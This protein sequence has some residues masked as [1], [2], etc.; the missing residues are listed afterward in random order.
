[1]THSFDLLDQPW[2][3]CTDT[4]GRPCLLGIRQVLLRADR[5][6]AI[7]DPSPLTTAALHRVLLAVLHRAFEGPRNDKQWARIREMRSWDCDAVRDYLDRWSGRFDLFHASHPF[8]QVPDLGVAPKGRAHVTKLALECA[9]GNNDTL[10][11]HSHETSPENWEPARVARQLVTAQAFSLGGGQSVR[12]GRFGRHPNYC[13]GPLVGKLFVLVAGRS[14]LETLALNLASYPNRRVQPDGDV[15]ADRPCWERDRDE[16]RAPG[17][18]PFDGYTDYLTW[19]SRYVRVH[20]GDSG[21]V[22]EIEITSGLEAPSNKIGWRDPLAIYRP[23]ESGQLVPVAMRANRALW[24][25]GHALLPKDQSRMA[26]N[27]SRAS[28]AARDQTRLHVFGLANDKAKA[29]VWRHDQFG[30]PASVVADLPRRE[31]LE[32]ALEHVDKVRRAL[33]ASLR[34]L[35]AELLSNQPESVPRQSTEPLVS[36]WNALPLFWESL[37]GP[38]HRFLGDLGGDWEAAEDRL[39]QAARDQAEE[40]LKRIGAAY[41]GRSPRELCARARAELR[42]AGRLRALAASRAPTHPTA[43]ANV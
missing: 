4:D 20:P 8:M 22:R 24:R 41:L 1:M 32:L 34:D 33:S 14:L 27:V 25:D 29:L 28:A 39:F 13:H 36:H 43:G 18:H 26:E 30:V 15:A 3:P 16:V 19:L 31:S 2:L 17:P 5:L 11:D 21:T 9:S 10:F 40:C 7:R 38:F 12:S 6:E 23:D 35:A 37:N 42:L